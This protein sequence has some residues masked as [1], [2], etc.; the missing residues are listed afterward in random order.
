MTHIWL[1]YYFADLAAKCP[2]PPILGRFSRVWS[3]NVVG[4]CRDPEK[5]HS[6]PETRVLAYRSYRSVKKWDLGARWRKQKRKIEKQKL[7]DLISHIAQTTYVA[8]PPRKLSCWWGPEHSQPCQVSS[9][10]VQGFWLPEG[11]KSAIFLCMPNFWLNTASQLTRRSSSV[12]R[13]TFFLL[14]CYLLLK[15]KRGLLKVK[16]S[17]FLSDA[18]ATIMDI[19]CTRALYVT[20]VR[21]GCTVWDCHFLT[22][23]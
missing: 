4:Y 11:S 19:V 5:A 1:F 21:S 22:I 10:S 9:K 2:F 14:A 17:S 18:S 13:T 8:L 3:L 12:W 7:R 6:W 20:A 16:C 15:T 23:F